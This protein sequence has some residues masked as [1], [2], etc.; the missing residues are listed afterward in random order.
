LFFFYSVSKIFPGKIIL[1]LKFSWENYSFSKFFPGKI[2]LFLKFS[3][4]NY[5]VSKIF[6]G[7]II[8]FL[9]FFLGKWHTRKVLFHICFVDGISWNAKSTSS[10]SDTEEKERML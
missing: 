1:F 7:K 3:W 4:E 6:P 8:L 10:P 5:S 9:K 2:I